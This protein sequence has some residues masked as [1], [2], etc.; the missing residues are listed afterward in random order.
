MISPRSFIKEWKQLLTLVVHFLHF[1]DEFEPKHFEHKQNQEKLLFEMKDVKAHLEA[2]MDK[3]N[4]VKLHFQNQLK[5]QAAGQSREQ[6]LKLQLS[7]EEAR[8]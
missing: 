5:N 8:R 6:E 3:L 4:S 7:E 2:A 1:K